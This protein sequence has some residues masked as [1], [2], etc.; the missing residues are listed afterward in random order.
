MRA[1]LFAA[2]SDWLTEA[3]EGAL[4]VLTFV[5]IVAALLVF[6]ATLRGW[7]R[8]TIGRRRD[9]YRRLARLGTNAQ[10][11]F[12]TSV[13]GEP[14]AIRRTRGARVRQSVPREE[15]ERAEGWE[16]VPDDELDEDGLNEE[17]VDDD[18][19]DD[20]VEEEIDVEE[21]VTVIRSGSP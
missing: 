15:Y 10:L 11:S 12:F 20:E 7:Y 9:R 18:E 17:L 5:P 1:S 14:P 2:S 13:L 3:G 8:R 4:D 21:W 6:A 19:L 16:I